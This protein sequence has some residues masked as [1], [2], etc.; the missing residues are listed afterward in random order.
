MVA[1]A[2]ERLLHIKEGIGLIRRLLD[3]KTIDH[4]RSDPVTRA[5]LERFLE[6]IS[7]ASRHVPEEWKQSFGPRIPWR[8]IA[9]FGNILRHV[10]DGV[11]VDVLWSVYQNDLDPLDQAVDAMLA[12]Y[13]PKD[14]APLSM[15]DLGDFSAIR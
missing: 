11:D 9:N 15:S 5:A 8:D 13:A 14:G 12:A 6:I 7:E 2:G 1:E 4:V 3:G 10:Y